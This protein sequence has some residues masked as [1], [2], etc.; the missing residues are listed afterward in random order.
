VVATPIGN[1]GDITFRAVE[2]LGEADVILAEDTRK[3]GLLLSRLGIRNKRFVSLFEHNEAS[4]VQSV[5]QMLEEG[6]RLALISSAGT[7]TIADPGYVL[8]RA[9]RLAGH[10]VAAVPGP[11]A[12]VTGLMVSGLPPIPYTFTGFMPRR[13][14]DKRRLLEPFRQVQTTLVFFERKSR[15]VET[16][17]VCHHVLGSRQ[18][19]LA[20]EL[21]KQFEEVVPFTLGETEHIPEELRGELTVLIGPPEEDSRQRSDEEAVRRCVQQE[22]LGGGKPKQIAAR[23]ERQVQGWSRKEIYELLVRDGSS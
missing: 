6:K 15:L 10:R 20:R 3:A 9:C 12:P 18:A 13:D 22:R 2:V 23:V 17:Q 21:T 19:C 14:R 5:L 4:R 1:L 11:S 16:L 8:V 7:P